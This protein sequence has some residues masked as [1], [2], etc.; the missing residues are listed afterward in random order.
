MSEST[1]LGL[2]ICVQSRVAQRRRLATPDVLNWSLNTLN[3]WSLLSRLVFS[4]H[5]SKELLNEHR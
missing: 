4:V 2:A 5:F 1:V 3:S